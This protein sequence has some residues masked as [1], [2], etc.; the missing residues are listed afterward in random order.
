MAKMYLNLIANT[1]NSTW[2]SSNIMTN[3]RMF[4]VNK[5]GVI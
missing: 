1:K 3:I 4:E 5:K 2:I